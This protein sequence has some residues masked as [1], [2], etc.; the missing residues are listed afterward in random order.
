[1]SRKNVVGIVAEYNPFHNGHAYH[2]RKAVEQSEAQAVVVV[3]SSNFVQ[4]GEPSFQDKWSRS[5]TAL[6]CG[7]DLVLELPVPFSCHNAGVFA[8]GAVGILAST[9]VVSHLS[10]G[11]EREIPRLEEI[12][13]ILLHEPL[14]FKEK[15]KSSL[16]QGM[17]YVEARASAIDAI[18]PGAKE[19]LSTPNNNLALAY[20]LE[21]RKRRVS[22]GITPVLRAGS[23]FHSL[24]LGPLASA[25]AIRKELRTGN[26]ERVKGS[27]PESSFRRLEKDIK[28]GH[29]TVDEWRLFSAYRLILA[30]ST[31]EELSRVA[32]MGEGFEAGMK[33]A[34]V[35]STDLEDL[36]SRCV[37]KRYPR[38]RVCRHFVH[39]LLG[40]EHW[41]NRAFQRLGPPCIRVL[42]ANRTGRRIL[43]EI[44]REATLP[45][46]CRCDE[47]NKGP[48]NSLMALERRATEIWETLTS[49][50]R[51]D[52]EKRAIPIL[53]P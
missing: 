9:G 17:S 43:R 2:I 42:G 45:V 1:M 44:R 47:T 34:I 14:P 18:V 3:L 26:I 41:E 31:R 46:L 4:R 49:S 24:E 20:L 52:A 7:A 38:G 40:F 11:M 6:E 37:S 29:C 39:A 5:A 13:D 53:V 15:L 51:L 22:L 19:A 36:F 16:M 48:I 12:L 8:K 23:G 21:V 50:P 35:H 28:E 32:E 27:M 10:F 33:E 30:R 25:S